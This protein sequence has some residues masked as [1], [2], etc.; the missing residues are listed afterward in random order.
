MFRA[1][2]RKIEFRKLFCLRKVSTFSI[3]KSTPRQFFASFVKNSGRSHFLPLLKVHL[4]ITK[5]S[6]LH[7]S[8]ELILSFALPTLPWYFRQK[9]FLPPT[10]F[11][12]IIKHSRSVFLSGKLSNDALKV[13]IVAWLSIGIETRRNIMNIEMENCLRQS[14]WTTEKIASDKSHFFLH[15]PNYL[16]NKS[17]SHRFLAE[18]YFP[19]ICF[20]LF[21]IYSLK[22]LKYEKQNEESWKV[23]DFAKKF[24]DH[25]IFKFIW[26]IIVGHRI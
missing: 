13:S 23:S 16:S 6:H 10:V 5:T 14:F 15:F 2:Y 11:A 18:N 1:W 22:I 24:R 21:S 17:L 3:I 26:L 8:E 12:H 20:L 7:P 4:L 25:S 19:K 9:N